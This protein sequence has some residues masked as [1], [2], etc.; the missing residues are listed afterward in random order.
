MTDA[1]GQ[2]PGSAAM[3]QQD[4]PPHVLQGQADAGPAVSAG[5]LIRQAREAAGLH[6]AALAVALKV[7]VKKLEALE[8]DRLDLLPD[9]VFVRA[10]AASVCRTLKIDAGQVLALL[11]QTGKPS[12]GQQSAPINTPF[13]SPGDGPGPSLLAQISRPAVLAGLLLLLGAL[14]LIFLPAVQQ[15]GTATQPATPSPAVADTP[16]AP[17]GA[18]SGVAMARTELLEVD[19]PPVTDSADQPATTAGMAPA[20]PVLAPQ[21][22]AVA[23]PPTAVSVA[24]SPAAAGII[25]FKAKGESWVEVT[26]A[27]GTVVL[28]R[29]L[30]AGE[31]AGA[32]GVLPLAAVVGRVDATQVEVRGK[33]FDLGAVS[34]DN[35]ARFEVK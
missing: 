2:L 14:V 34:K 35:V 30:A 15:P 25:V 16:A 10:L 31:E 6:I 8:A 7:P 32:S 5:S 19:K 24:V 26:D 11:P 29:T 12:L 13:R 3:A 23:P 18:L 27:R 33:A 4:S 22:S 9:A 28:R 17:S 1:D 21:P 20:A